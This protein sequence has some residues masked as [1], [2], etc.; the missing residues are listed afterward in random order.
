MIAQVKK[1]VVNTN[2]E[3]DLVIKRLHLYCYMKSVT[4][5][6]DDSSD[7]IIQFPAFEQPYNQS[8]L[9]LYQI[10]IIPVPIIDQ[11]IHAKSYT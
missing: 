9:T 8:P 10:E 7:I 6:T 4:F 11:N 3:Y 5:C 2:P 1:A